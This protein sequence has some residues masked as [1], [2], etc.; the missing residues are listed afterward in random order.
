MNSV[1]NPESRA[2]HHRSEQSGK[3]SLRVLFGVFLIACLI[4]LA[5]VG[6]TELYRS[7]L[8]REAPRIT[9]LDTPRGIGLAP[10]SLRIRFSDDLSGL[11]EIV[12]RAKQRGRSTEILRRKLGG[13]AKEEVTLEFNSRES[14]FEEGSVELEIRAFDRSI[15]SNAAE[16][17]VVLPVDFRRPRL[18]VISTQHNARRGG[19]QLIVYEASDENLGL[20]GVKVGQHT[21]L[22][23]QARLMDPAFAQFP[24]LHV[25]LYAIPLEEE[26]TPRIRLFAEDR[27][28]NASSATF[29]NRILARR[30]PR[31]RVNISE[32][33]LRGR[34]ADLVSA[35]TNYIQRH[36]QRLGSSFEFQTPSGSRERLVENF[37]VANTLLRRLTENRVQ[38]YLSVSRHDFYWI[39]ALNPQAGV[40]RRG[41][42]EELGFFWEDELL[43]QDLHA[44]YIYGPRSTGDKV[45]AA[46]SGVVMFSE[47]LGA[48]GSAVG[49]DHG[50]G[51][52]SIYAWLG[53][54]DVQQG[55]RIEAG[56]SIASYG[57][58]GFATRREMYFQTRVHGIPVDPTE[59]L[60]RSWYQS[61]I[62]AKIDEAKRSL[63]IPVRPPL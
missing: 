8:E 3:I 44:G 7:F 18:E 49:I 34:I 39:R 26:G 38:G 19:S 43:G 37:Q 1:F 14:G 52:V 29:H 33:Y 36:K 24:N 48:L 58:S 10:V 13:A 17:S 28:G 56:E 21:F 20:S 60:S 51:L 2:S 54:R 59:W 53:A 45:L 40:V 30:I 50:L 6:W 9:L 16:K 12:V 11:D 42:G 61:H 5:L 23:F 25:A 63:G 47:D 31:N 22:G 55:T 27:V 15:W 62:S 41:Y 35:N 32:Q 4:P 57:E 46:G